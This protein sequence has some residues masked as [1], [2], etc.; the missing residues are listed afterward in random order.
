MWNPTLITVVNGVANS[1]QAKVEIKSRLCQR[2]IQ[3]RSRVQVI[4]VKVKLRLR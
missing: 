4:Q 2:L 1:G 3:D